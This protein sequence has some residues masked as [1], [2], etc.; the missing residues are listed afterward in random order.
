MDSGPLCN[1]GTRPDSGT[2]RMLK[3]DGDMILCGCPAASTLSLSV[4]LLV[5]LPYWDLKISDFLKFL[6]N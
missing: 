3:R 4:P 6:S 1:G 2:N 5:R